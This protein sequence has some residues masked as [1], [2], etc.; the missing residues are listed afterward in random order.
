M[1]LLVLVWLIAAFGHKSREERKR[2]IVSYDNMCHL[3][4]LKAAKKPLP[5]PED[6]QYLWLDVTKIIDELH[7]KNHADKRC[8]E[9][10]NPKEALSEDMN[11]MS[12]EQTFAWLFRFKKI[13]SAMPKT[14]HHVYLHCMIQ[15][16]N[17]YISKCYAEGRRP[18]HATKTLSCGIHCNDILYILQFTSN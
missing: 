10:Y 7:I 18:V 17:M 14:H 16:R 3:N 4:N 11:T 15:R 9:K 13:P 2:I 12:C 6:L 1:F 8:I 5:L